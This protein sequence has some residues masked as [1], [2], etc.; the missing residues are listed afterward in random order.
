MKKT[1]LT[2][3]EINQSGKFPIIT[4]NERLRNLDYSTTSFRID[5][6]NSLTLVKEE[7]GIQNHVVVQMQGSQ[8][9]L[10]KFN[11]FS[12]AKEFYDYIANRW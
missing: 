2:T 9:L 7:E 5:R 8:E 12:E 6:I 11:S 3:E 1:G 10:F 4:T